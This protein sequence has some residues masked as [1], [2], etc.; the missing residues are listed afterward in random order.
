MFFIYKITNK[1]NNKIYIGQVYNKTIYDRFK[2]HIK[3]ASENSCM[4]ISRAIYKYGKENFI[5]EEIDR[6]EDKDI[7]KNILIKGDLIEI[8]N[9]KI[10]LLNEK[11]KYWIAKYNSTNREIGYNLT[12]GGEGGNTY[13]CKSNDELNNIKQK[14]SNSNKGINNGMSHQ[15]KAYNIE[16]NKEYH[17]NT[18]NETL[19]F[20]KVK[21]KGVVMSI[22][23]GKN[24]FYYRNKWNFAYENNEYYK[25]ICIRPKR[26]HYGIKR[27][28][29]INKITGD[30]KIFKSIT[31]AR[32]NSTLICRDKENE[33]YK[34]IELL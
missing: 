28:K 11:E 27:C 14:I 8:K 12:I 16:T 25:D 2:R 10:K 34:I 4:Y 5:I 9:E 21:N 22:V 24:K 30:E 13:I 33:E 7:D 1:I 3:S 18:L 23:N 6:V 19:N 31:E 32:K 26:K 29:L 20:L 15:I 17:F